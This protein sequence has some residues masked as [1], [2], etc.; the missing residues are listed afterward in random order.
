MI[1][2]FLIILSLLITSN[3]F[4]GG[5][6]LPELKKEAKADNDGKLYLE[7]L[8]ILNAP[9][10]INSVSLSDKSIFGDKSFRFEV[11]HGECSQ[12]PKWSDCENERERSELYYQWKDSQ[13]GAASD[14]TWKKE[15]WYRFYLFIPKDFNSVVPAKTSLIQWK[16]KKP[17][18]VIIMFQYHKGGLFLNMNGDT[19]RR[20]PWYLMKSDEEL[21]GQW[22]EILFNT[23]WHPDSD[24]GYMKVWIDGEMKFDYTGKA[25]DGGKGKR[26]NL[27]YGIYNSFLQ[28]YR[29]ATGN[30]TYPQRVVYFD[31]V[32]G[33]TTCEKLLKD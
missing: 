3:A 30:S 13:F 4:A 29:K 21:R 15:K 19:F 24:K 22:T 10:A 33:D 32:K 2:S 23:N 14:E 9:H 31:G 16:R 11:N 17:S 7:G 12:E 20:D 25:N 6:N 8:S 27:R 26:L 1:K 28:K 5:A 18:K